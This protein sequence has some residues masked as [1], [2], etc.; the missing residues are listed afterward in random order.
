M[1]YMKVYGGSDT[2]CRHY[3]HFHETECTDN[4]NYLQQTQDLVLEHQDS[5]C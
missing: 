3:Y 2:K 4:K 5:S 1:I